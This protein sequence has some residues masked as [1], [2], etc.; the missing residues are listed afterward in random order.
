[1]EWGLLWA[2]SCAWIKKEVGGSDVWKQNPRGIKI[3]I[4]PKPPEPGI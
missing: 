3:K 1:V 4:P 2:G